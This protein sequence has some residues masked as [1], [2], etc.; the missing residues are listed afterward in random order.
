MLRRYLFGTL[1]LLSVATAPAYAQVKLEWKF[2]EGEQFTLEA[3]MSSKEKALYLAKEQKMDLTLVFL[4]NFKVL[5]KFSDVT[6]LELRIESI[7]AERADVASLN[8]LLEEF[9]GSK[10]RVTLSSK[11]QLQR[12]EGYLQVIDGIAKGDAVARARI[13]ENFPEENLKTLVTETFGALPDKPISVNTKWGGKFSIPLGSFGSL[14]GTTDY[15]YLGPVD[16]KEKIGVEA[17][18]TGYT[19]PKRG[20]EVAP[21]KGESPKAENVKGAIFFDRVNGKLSSSE[22]SMTIKGVFRVPGPMGQE[23]TAEMSQERSIRLKMVKK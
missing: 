21:V 10:F 20:T 3:V 4:F 13:M 14:S 12:F 16:D 15:T 6:N 2:K 1:I 19:P 5:R 23:T 11:M 17:R 7:R 8:Q 22:V 18:V 9:R